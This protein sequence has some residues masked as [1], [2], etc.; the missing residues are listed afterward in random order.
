MCEI[1]KYGFTRAGMLL[2]EP[3]TADPADII[4][5]QVQ[6]IWGADPPAG[7]TVFAEGFLYK[8]GFDTAY[9][10]SAP[11]IVSGLMA[12]ITIPITGVTWEA[13]SVY[14]L[15]QV[16]IT[17]STHVSLIC[18]G[19]LPLA[20]TTL[21]P[22]ALPPVD[23][24]TKPSVYGLLTIPDNPAAGAAFTIK[25]QIINSGYNG[26]VRAVFTVDGNQISD[27]N[28]TLNT[29]PGGGLWEPTIASTMTNAVTTITVDVYG[30]DGTAWVQDPKRT[31]QTLTITRSPS[32]VS[33]T[34]VSIDPYAAI[35]ATAGEKVT[36]KATVTPA[37]TAFDVAFK[38]RAGTVLGTCKTSGGV[39]T[40]I[41]DSTGK[42]AGTTYYVQA[43]VAEGIC[44]STETSITVLPATKQWDVS[45][46]VL[47]S[48]L[49]S[50]IPG[51][52]VTV[53]TQS[54][55]TDAAGMALFRVDEG[56]IPISI[57]KTGYTIFNTIELVYA[58][59][60][61]TYSLAATGI[62]KGSIQFVSVPSEA[63][64]WLAPTGKAVV[65]QGVQTPKTITDL[66]AGKYTFVFKRAGYNDTTGEVTV[67]GGGTVQAYA[68]LAPISPTTGGLSL[69]STPQGANI[70]IKDVDQKEFTPKTITGLVPG[71]YSLKLTYPNYK[72]WTGTVTIIA[73][74]TIYLSPVLMPLTTIGTL[75]LSSTPTKARVFLDGKDQLR[76]TPATIF[77]LLPKSYDLKLVLAGYNDAVEKVI[78]ESGKTTALS[79]TMVKQ[80]AGI[81]TGTII[82]IA[83]G[84]AA[85]ILGLKA[86]SS[87]EGGR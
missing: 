25:A 16:A 21:T 59:K 62:A 36:F 87:K 86:L 55:V 71:T 80:E 84:I 1:T 42:T 61:F 32:A 4:G 3:C 26:K 30:W 49:Y 76:E 51:A 19:G 10:M 8:N 73:G 63:Q 78:V 70:F 69:Y 47:D 40:F 52:T 41:W 29:F 9:I 44:N 67:T 2:N 53:G 66:P 65:D 20:C 85:G 22:A 39:C 24:V 31:D 79:I 14:T 6:V 68:T 7:S 56:T 23:T 75:E 82:V 57:S 34:D 37:T 43:T 50:L 18:S 74:K 45:I 48:V 17:D 28:S 11:V 5:A 77:N 72:D 54:K 46:Y 60:T 12:I 38:D 27:Q 81:G 15:R 58:N 33:C 64:I 35:T 13:G 83:A